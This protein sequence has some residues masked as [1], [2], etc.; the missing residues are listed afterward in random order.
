MNKKRILLLVIVSILIMVGIALSRNYIPALKNFFVQIGFDEPLNQVEALVASL[1]SGNPSAAVGLAVSCAG[2]LST[3]IGIINT[4][5]NDAKTKA[6][7]IET[8]LMGQLTDKGKELD[9]LISNS[10]SQITTLTDDLTEQKA[11]YTALNGSY[12]RQI[13]DN[14]A[15]LTENS[16]LKSQVIELNEKL[17]ATLITLEQRSKTSAG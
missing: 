15:V 12:N 4:R 6:L 7:S 9:T 16:A 3:I 10:E 14:N 8:S 11:A 2:G 1:V 17:S 5:S 13:E